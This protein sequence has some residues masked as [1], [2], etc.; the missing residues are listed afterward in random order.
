VLTLEAVTWAPGITAPVG[1][2][3]VPKTVPSCV[4]DQP[5]VETNAKNRANSKQGSCDADFVQGRTG[6]TLTA[7]PTTTEIGFVNTPNS[8]STHDTPGRGKIYCALVFPDR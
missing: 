3:M 5:H 7:M 2:V 4:W 1:S 8:N 6:A